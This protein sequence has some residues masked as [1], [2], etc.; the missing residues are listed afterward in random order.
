MNKFDWLFVIGTILI[1]LLGFGLVYYL[2]TTE[3][4][5]IKDPIK[6]YEKQQDTL[7]SCGNLILPKSHG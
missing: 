1:L 6:Y 2:Q 5:C 4:E 7:C 3:K